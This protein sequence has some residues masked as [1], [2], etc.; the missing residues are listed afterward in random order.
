MVEINEKYPVVYIPMFAD[1][2]RAL[3]AVMHSNA[4][5]DMI[6]DRVMRGQLIS[7]VTLTGARTEL[8]S[9]LLKSKYGIDS[10]ILHRTFMRL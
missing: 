4:I 7:P 3:G 5:T 8:I 2:A 1:E 6:A 9:D 10:I